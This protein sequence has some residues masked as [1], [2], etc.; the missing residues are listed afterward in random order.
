M[1]VTVIMKAR[2]VLERVLKRKIYKYVGETTED[3]YKG[4]KEN[5]CEDFVIAVSYFVPIYVRVC[6]N[7][8]SAG[9][10]I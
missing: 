10:E 6:K 2:E 5:P 4:W 1:C 9:G 8:L 7:I 3:E